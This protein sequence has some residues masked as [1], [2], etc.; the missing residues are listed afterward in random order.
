MITQSLIFPPRPRSLRGFDPSRPRERLPPHVPPPEGTG[1]H[2]FG[3]IDP[4]QKN[5]PDFARLLY[6]QPGH[7]SL[8]ECRRGRPIATP[9]A[10]H[11]LQ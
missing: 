7:F 4:G 9:T 10:N 8:H 5:L 2:H 11:R 6:R 1:L 3:K